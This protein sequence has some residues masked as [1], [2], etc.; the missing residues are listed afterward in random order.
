MASHVEDARRRTRRLVAGGALEGRKVVLFGASLLSEHVKDEL[1]R[2][3]ITLHAVI[4]NSPDKVGRPWAGVS[5]ERPDAVLLPPDPH[6][7][8]LVVSAVFAEEMLAQLAGL[9]YT[10]EPQV[11]VVTPPAGL[12]ARA[13]GSRVWRLWRGRRAYRR[14]MGRRPGPLFVAPYEGTGD[15]HL[16]GLFF[17]EYVRRNGIGD[18]VVAVPNRACA[19]IA[20][21]AGIASVV[22]APAV[23]NDIV[24]Y[25]RFVNGRGTDVVVLNDG[26]WP[27]DGWPSERTQWL[28]GYRGLDFEKMFRHFVFGLDASVPHASPASAADPDAVTELMGRH[29]LEPGRTVVLAPYANTL[30]ERPDPAFWE[31]AAQALTERG[32]T[33]CTNCAGDEQPVRGTVAVAV[34]FES[35]V[36]FMDRAGFFVGVRSG[37]CDVISGSSCRKIVLYDADGRFYKASFREYFSLRSMGLSPDAVELEYRRGDQAS[38]VAT[39]TR[40]L[41]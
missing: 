32:F 16:I 1:D 25:A 36:A 31:Q 18:H 37:L 15:L 23:L 20:A 8:V 13:F 11:Q 2:A 9:G 30:F 28:R 38:L 26:C 14:L 17:A 4:D 6:L 10:G 12:S 34:P 39:I 27:S 19:R 21:M 33:V 24:G 41:A 29:G 40:E 7:V 35:M 22:V 3:G 5:V